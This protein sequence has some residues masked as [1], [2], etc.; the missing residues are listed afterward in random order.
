MFITAFFR[1]ATDRV[2]YTLHD[3]KRIRVNTMHFGFEPADF[4]TGQYRVQ[5]LHI[6]VL[7]SRFSKTSFTF[8]HRDALAQ[9]VRDHFPYI[10]RFDRDDRHTR[11]LF[12]TLQQEVNS[13][14]SR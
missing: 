4:K 1:H 3:N 6:M 9:L 5:D 14:G 7:V 8:I 12:N 11:I 2:F 13:F 10:I